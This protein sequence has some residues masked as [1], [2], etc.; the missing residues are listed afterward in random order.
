MRLIRVSLNHHR[1][2]QAIIVRMEYFRGTWVDPADSASNME[3]LLLHSLNE[4]NLIASW[5]TLATSSLIIIENWSLISLIT[6]LVRLRF[7]N[8][9]TIKFPIALGV[10]VP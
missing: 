1:V 8:L 2:V 5:A 6:H 7:Q 3:S 10:A 9:F 4:S